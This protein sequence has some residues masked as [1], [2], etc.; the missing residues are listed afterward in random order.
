MKMPCLTVRNALL[1]LFLIA[2]CEQDTQPAL[3]ASDFRVLAPP[4]GGNVAVA[5][6]NLHNTS[7]SD[8]VVGRISSPDFADVAMHE[9][10]LENGITTMRPLA[11]LTIPA[12][13]SL[14]FATGGKHVM[15]LNGDV[16][17]GRQVT[18]V[19]EYAGGTL[20]LSAAI[21]DRFETS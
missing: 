9:T 1:L 15:L 10:K 14:E 16:S 3:A 21:R 20:Q 4:P 7:N 13:S 18:I 6:F 11:D 8:V 19:I 5:Y 17:P 2:A 12:G